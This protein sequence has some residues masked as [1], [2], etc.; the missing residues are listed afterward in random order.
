MSRSCRPTKAAILTSCAAKENK[1]EASE[2][3]ISHH[4]HAPEEAH[5]VIHCDK[6]NIG[7]A[8]YR[9]PVLMESEPGFSLFS[10]TRFSREPVSTSLENALDHPPSRMTIGGRFISHMR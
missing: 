5:P 9:S 1:Q 10:L 6:I 4:C 3:R 8:G 2:S 7:A